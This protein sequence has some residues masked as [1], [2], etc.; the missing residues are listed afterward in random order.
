METGRLKKH[1]PPPLAQQ[2]FAISSLHHDS[3]AVD[4]EKSARC[5]TLKVEKEA[6]QLRACPCP[7]AADA[8]VVN[9]RQRQDADR[10][11]APALLSRR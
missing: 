10:M 9:S 7:L 1:A 2:E 6:L 5:L 11:N 4:G 3:N 8:E